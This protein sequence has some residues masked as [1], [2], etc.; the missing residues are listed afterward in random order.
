[1]FLLVLCKTH[2]WAVTLAADI[3]LDEQQSSRTGKGDC[4]EKSGQNV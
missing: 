2:V 1:M 3:Q 4:T